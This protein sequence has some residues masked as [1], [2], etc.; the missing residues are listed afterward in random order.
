[1]SE[2]YTWFVMVTGD[3][4]VADDEHVPGIYAFEL[5]ASCETSEAVYAILV[6]F[7]RR[8]GIEEL[9]AFEIAVVDPD[10]R[11]QTD[12]RPSGVTAIFAGRVEMGAS[13]VARDL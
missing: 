13:A 11:L 8:I 7:H 1:M 2:F 4:C 3:A 9:D 10:G 12:E 6:E 5:E